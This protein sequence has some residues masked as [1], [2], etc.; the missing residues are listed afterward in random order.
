MITIKRASY[1]RGYSGDDH[2]LNDGELSDVIGR[3]FR[4]VKQA[5]KEIEKLVPKGVISPVQIEVLFD[6]GESCWLTL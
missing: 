3:T 1:A 4:D 2:M 6:D 5:K